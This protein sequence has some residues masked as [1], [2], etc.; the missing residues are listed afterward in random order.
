LLRSYHE[1]AGDD[2]TPLQLKFFQASVNA[3]EKAVKEKRRQRQLLVGVL[4]TGL[5][6]TSGAAIFA[7]YQ[8]QQAQRQRVEQLAATAELLLSSQK[9]VDAEVTA[10]VAK[11]LAQSA[12]VQFP[13]YP[14]FNSV[15]RELLDAI[16]SNSERIRMV[17]STILRNADGSII[18]GGTR[19]AYFAAFSTDGNRIFSADGRS[20]RI[21]D[22]T[23]GQPITDI[24]EGTGFSPDG[25]R[26]VIFKDDYTIE[27]WDATTGKLIS[28]TSPLIGFKGFKYNIFSNRLAFSSDGSRIVIYKDD[29]T[30]GIWDTTTGKPISESIP[31]IELKG[32]VRTV[33]FSPDGKRV[34]VY[35]DDSTIGIWDAMTGKP[36][37]QTL[38][39]IE[40]LGNVESVTFSADGNRMVSLSN[41]NDHAFRLSVRIWDATTGK[42]ICEPLQL[43]RNGKVIA[44]TFSPDSR[45]VAI[46]KDDNTSEILDATIGKPLGK[47]LQGNSVLFSLDGKQVVTSTFH[48]NTSHNTIRMWD[49]RTGDPIGKPLTLIGHS[50]ANPVALSSDGK[51]VI[52]VGNDSTIRAWDWHSQMGQPLHI[53]AKWNGVNSVAIS[54]DGKRVF[55]VSNDHTIRTWNTTTGK[56]ISDVLLSAAGD[57]KLGEWERGTI[58]SLAISLDGKRVVIYLWNNEVLIRDM[59]TGVP[60]DKPLQGENAAVNSAAFSP[61]GKWV[62]IG[63]DN[64]NIKI[65]DTTTGNP[66][67]NSLTRED[68]SRN[69]RGNV[70]SVAFS[71]DSTLI[72]GSG[73]VGVWDVRT[74]KPIGDPIMG[75]FV[76]FSPDG[77]RIVSS[78][79]N[80]R[81]FS[82]PTIRIWD[83]RMG[84]PI[85]DPIMGRDGDIESVALSPDGQRIVSGSNDLRNYS[86]TIRI[87]D[88]RTGNPIGDPIIGRDGEIGSVAFSSD[89]KQV[90]Y[91][92]N[93]KKEEGVEESVSVGS[94]NLSMVNL[95]QVACE[96][97]RFHSILTDPT[98]DIAREAKQ[99]CEH[100]VWS[101]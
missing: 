90:F 53:E 52:S 55:G 83:A 39:F 43:G 98:T 17:N 28:K 35:K 14:P 60:I 77:Q 2:M 50:M 66:I 67:G 82:T 81:Q 37:S 47:S 65:F 74:G 54:P 5:V 6:L 33:T 21:W 30:I 79:G 64:L 94:L 70:N 9:P 41:S 71:P 92:V 45:R 38:P 12:F 8:V 80:N 91:V 76:A 48:N 34:V 10:I 61:D 58:K 69:I 56:I 49:A 27:I 18:G 11:G 15:S 19:S 101:K 75:Q 72:V 95:L 87:W 13:D 63:Y 73:S 89:G 68:K 23:T 24:L 46:S 78:S 86:W 97:L 20:L 32:T 99:T 29:N 3:T 59:S 100:Y 16:R 85:G 26:I 51:R 88:A 4:S 22:A 44:L 57:K 7:L 36:I 1:R 42:P 84:K 62:A 93:D 96:Q 31:L 40:T 25:N